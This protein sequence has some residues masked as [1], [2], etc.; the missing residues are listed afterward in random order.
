MHKQLFISYS[1]LSSYSD[2]LTAYHEPILDL[3]NTPLLGNK[4]K[5]FETFTYNNNEQFYSCPDT[6]LENYF[7]MKDYSVYTNYNIKLLLD[8]LVT[9]IEKTGGDYHLSLVLSHGF[10]HSEA[11]LNLDFIIKN[12][13]IDQKNT[14]Q[15]FFSCNP[16]NIETQ[17]D[18]TDFLQDL[19]DEIIYSDDPIR[20]GCEW[21][22]IAFLD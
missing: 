9:N 14:Y 6:F 1:D 15:T 11:Y 12:Q 19:K 21:V 16:K 7:K 22:C 20:N 5:S 2:L 18:L 4:K 3:E 10:G 8:E 13:R 17:K